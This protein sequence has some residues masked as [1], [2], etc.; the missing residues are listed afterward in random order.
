MFK[1]YFK[2]AF[3][4]L[5]KRKIYSIINIAGLAIGL[6]CCILIALFIADE[7][8]YDKFH[9]KSDRIYRVT[10]DFWGDKDLSTLH[11]GHVAPPFG[12]LLK[13]HFPDIQEVVRFYPTS[14]LFMIKDRSFQEENGYYVEPSAFKIFDFKV[15]KGDASQ[16]LN[17]PRTLMLSTTL[18]KKY[19]GQENPIGKIISWRYGGEKLSLKVTGVFEPLPDNSHFHP[20]YMI[21]F[22]T[23]DNEKIYGRKGLKRNWGNNSFLTY[24]LLPPNYN[25][26]NIADKLDEFMNNTYGAFALA[27]KW[28]TRG[29]KASDFTHLYLQKLTD[30]HLHSH[31]DSEAE[32]NGDI[33]NVYVFAIIGLFIL[34]IACINFINLSTAR[35]ANRAKEVGIRKV[36]GAYRQHLIFQFLS[37]A[38][39][40]TLIALVVA[41]GLVE[42]M[43]PSLNEF[44]GKNLSMNYFSNTGII[45]LLI[46]FMLLVGI[47]AGFYPAL[48]LSSFQPVKVLKGRLATG[49]KNSTLRTVLVVSQFSIS[50]VLIVCTAIVYQ[51]LSFVKNKSLGLDKDHVIGLRNNSEINDKFQT[52]RQELLKNPLIKNLGRSTI[53]PSQR[54]LNS[55]GSAEEVELNDSIQKSNVELRMVRADHDFLETFSIPLV[56]GRYF[57]RKFKTDDSAAFFINETAAKRIGWKNPQDAVGTRFKYD[58]RRGTIIGVMKD[59]NFESMHEPVKPLVMFM[60][61]DNWY[62]NISIKLQ[63]KNIK[64]TLA[65]IKQA[66]EKIVPEQPF[67]YQFVDERFARLYEKEQKQGS[68][69][70]VFAGLAIMIACLGL[71]G[72]TSF[73][74][75][76]RTKEIGIRKVLGASISSI[77]QLVSRNFVVLVLMAT[78]IALPLAFYGMNRWLESFAYHINLLNYWYVFLASGLVALLIA[79]A[80]ISSQVLKVARVNPSQVLRNE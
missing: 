17:K 7:T 78:G 61:R 34:L 28:M 16:A 51:Q 30:I 1:N 66:W 49:S 54:L 15:T 55:S 50:I 23:L 62:S 36:V 9:S 35:S 44:I 74:A 72:L 73:I 80:T 4:N 20:N 52:F 11:L 26:K 5:F 32:A 12:P 58:R 41:I 24:I 21:S 22:R 56:K 69:F 40:M 60:R 14:D 2:V 57:S 39:M 65:Y 47:L 63:G 13:Q 3:R 68:L 79:L 67:A 37:E 25:S 75:E 27:Q 19:F 42:A 6:T 53:A 71:Y 31:L 70:M 18:A 48:F 38:V 29:K 45:L 76:Q 59:F 64:E 46:G 43:L 10:R 33:N 8:S 77:L